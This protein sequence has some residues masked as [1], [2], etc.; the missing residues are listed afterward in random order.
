MVPDQ[1]S[2]AASVR[3]TSGQVCRPPVVSPVRS[4]QRQISPDVA[5]PPSSSGEARPPAHAAPVSLCRRSWTLVAFATVSMAAGHSTVPL[6][7]FTKLL[8]P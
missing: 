6:F 8:C 4:G 1:S 5:C 2:V 3:S 7:L